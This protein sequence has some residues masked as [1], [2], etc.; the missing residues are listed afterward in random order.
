[1]R[2]VFYF[3]ADWCGP[4]KRVKPIVADLDRDGDIK[5]QLIDVDSNFELV[6]SYQ[7]QSVPT[8]VLIEDNKEIARTTGAQTREQLEAFINQPSE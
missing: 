4:C 1:M 5:F 7:I 2:H 6:K 8:F 3:T